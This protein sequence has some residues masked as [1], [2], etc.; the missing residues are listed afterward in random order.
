MDEVAPGGAAPGGI[1]PGEF[2]PAAKRAVYDAIALRRD[3]R[4]FRPDPVPDDVL[5][6]VLEAAHRAG[7]V[8][9]MQPWDFIL[10]RSPERKAEVYELFRR[11]TE[12]AAARYGDDRRA[13]YGA[14]KL[15]GILDAPL[16]VCVT[17]DTA[18]GGPH[19]LGRDS[20]PEMDRYSTCLA[21]Q[22]LWLAARAEGVGVGWVSIVDNVD[23]A[24]ALSLPPHVVP[25]AF[26]CVG[27]PVEFAPSPM[28][29]ATGW[30]GR[31]PLDAL[32]HEERWG[33]RQSV[34]S[35]APRAGDSPAG[36]PDPSGNPS[37]DGENDPEA[38]L[39]AL[40]AAVCPADPGGARAARV[41]A[42]LAA[43]AMPPGSM[44]RLEDL[45][46]RLAAAQGRDAPTAD[47]PRVLVFAG[48]HGVAVEGVSAYRAE[49]TARLCYNMVAGGAVV[50]ALLRP[51]GLAPEVVD[52]GVDHAFGAGARVGAAKVR[53]GTRNLAD[54]P[55]M[56]RAEAIAAL[57]AGAGAVAAGAPADL[58]ALGEV[59]IGNTT[60]AAALLALLTG[61]S[62]DDVVGAG[63]GVGAR[64]R[65]RK[66]AL[67]ARALAR[68]RD[69]GGDQ[70]R[71][72]TAESIADDPIAAL[73][74]VGGLEI[75][76]LTGAVLA[77][78]AHRAPVLLDGFITAAAALVAVRLAPA[79]AD[80]LVPSHRSAER[81]HGLALEALGLA[82]G[83]AGP[84]AAA[85]PLLDLG[86][87]LGEGSGAALALPLARAACALLTDVRTFAEAG[88][89]PP[90]DARG[91]E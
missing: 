79:A 59:G 80:Y 82:G 65:A 2:A 86:L 18:R 72:N 27:Y 46:V 12:R 87:R 5:R 91:A 14:L 64:A 11:A 22:N 24:R 34:Q 78:A 70:G 54:G 68:T 81:A 25:V 56:T 33:P 36:A 85:G 13:A 30:R 55:T 50:N 84:G 48:D 28:L 53:R 66:T 47:R 76:A 77:A 7:S 9:F 44:G 21:V 83:N 6:R 23:L 10:V 73:A 69:Q 41:R 31:L 20:I 26:L 37:G 71:A 32:I 61:A 49:V 17:C 8:G 60:S 89:D 40:A 1:V 4:N 57:L 58:L 3:V 63:T 45:A 90:V 43:L 62:A 38:R 67:V 88:I 35:N 74:A 51:Q 42:R 15:Q 75:A 19:V 52:V 29:E 39:R 16:S